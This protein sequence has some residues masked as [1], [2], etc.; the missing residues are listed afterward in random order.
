METTNTA[1]QE[2]IAHIRGMIRSGELKPGDRFPAER[3]LA[4]QL[5][6]SRNTVREA[7]HYFEAIGLAS[8]RR[9]SG[10]YLQDDSEALQK[11]MDARQ[12]LERYSWNE[13]MQARRVIEMG[14]VQAAARSATRDDKLRLRDA[15]KKVEATGKYTKTDTAIEA[16]I[17]ADYEFH[18]EIARITH[19]AILLELHTVIKGVILASA[20]IWK[21]VPDSVNVGNPLHAR[22]TETIANNDP[23]AA[24]EAMEQHMVHMEKLYLLSQL[25]R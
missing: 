21:N 13:M 24:A 16:H 22:I 11:V 19:N 25:G 4:Q 23:A 7:L 10:T 14:I 3:T 8:T 12:I 17:L 5:G 2:V 6:V 15:L 20:D 9:G 1:A 18:Q